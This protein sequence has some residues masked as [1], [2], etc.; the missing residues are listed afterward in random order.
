MAST[1]VSTGQI[2]AIKQLRL[3]TLEHC[4]LVSLWPLF[5]LP[6][7]ATSIAG[8]AYNFCSPRSI[9]SLP[10]ATPNSRSTRHPE[11]YKQAPPMVTAYRTPTSL[12]QGT[13][14]LPQEKSPKF[15]HPKARPTTACQRAFDFR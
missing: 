4:L 6:G 3:A 12:W 5:H 10:S 2:R 1:V 7:N 14:K 9:D 13:T 8:D 11:T 15:Q